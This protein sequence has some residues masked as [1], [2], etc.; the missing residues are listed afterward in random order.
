M[1]VRTLLLFA[2]DPS[3]GE[4]VLAGNPDL[5]LDFETPLDDASGQ[6]LQAYAQ[7]HR[8]GRYSHPRL[9]DGGFKT[10]H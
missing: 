7:Y 2:I 8:W 6:Y 10:C 5:S 3:T 1:R 4:L 9:R